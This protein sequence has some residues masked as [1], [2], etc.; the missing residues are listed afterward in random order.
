MK[1]G[2]LPQKLAPSVRAANRSGEFISPPGGGSPPRKW[3]G[4]PAETSTLTRLRM[5]PR[6]D[7]CRFA[8]RQRVEAAV[9]QR[10]EMDLLHIR[11]Q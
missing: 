11:W 1:A 10:F 8:E 5:A 6:A 9:P 7:G 4:K 3:R 2:K